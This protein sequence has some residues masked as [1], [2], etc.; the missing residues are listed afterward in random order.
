MKLNKEIIGAIAGE[1]TKIG[2][3]HHAIGEYL[4]QLSQS[5]EIPTIEEV[6]P[7]AKVEKKTAPKKETATKEVEAD[8][9]DGDEEEITV[10]D[11]EA[12]TLK[13]L[14]ELAT[15][16]EIEFPSKV[17][18]DALIALIV[19]AMGGEEDEAE[20]EADQADEGSEEEE[21]D[22]EGIDLEELSVAELK[23]FI[24]ENLEGVKV[25]AKKKTQKAEAYRQALIALIEENMPEEDEGEE[26]AGDEERSTVIETEDGDV[27]LA[28]MN[29]KE[30]K[31]FAK[32]Y[33]LEV[34][35]KRKDDLIEEIL[36]QIY[37][38]GDAEGEDEDGEDDGEAV[39]DVAD[40]LGLNDM[41]VEELAEILEEHGLSTKGKK[42]ALIDRIVRAIE[43]GTIELDDENEGE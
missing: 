26:E 5:D 3:A 14:K 33:E 28:D 27:D 24:E 43:D 16:N 8:T 30:L 32:E 17:K 6:L 18:K 35:A 7:T 42:Q 41:E 40:E 20:D 36:D 25:P 38:E 9:T 1:Y 2:N 12:M 34:S 39:E 31:A 29:V 10:D 23:S 15:E 4:K 22:E 21:G 19:E 11:L 13:E 37:A